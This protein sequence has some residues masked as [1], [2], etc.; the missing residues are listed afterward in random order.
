MNQIHFIEFFCKTLEQSYDLGLTNAEF[1]VDLTQISAILDIYDR[2]HASPEI[3]S[4]VKL[5]LILLHIKSPFK[6]SK[7]LLVPT[8]DLVW[9]NCT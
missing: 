8:M 3:K 9:Q 4:A 1:T 5:L 6:L 2:K 7:N